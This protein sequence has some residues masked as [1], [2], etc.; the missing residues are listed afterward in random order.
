MDAKVADSAVGE[1][2]EEVTNCSG[3]FDEEGV[4][5]GGEG[6]LIFAD[7]DSGSFL[8]AGWMS[9]EECGVGEDGWPSI[10]LFDIVGDEFGDHWPAPITPAATDRWFPEETV[11]VADFCIRTSR[12]LR[13]IF[14]GRSIDATPNDLLE[15]GKSAE[16]GGDFVTA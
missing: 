7:S 5:G 4:V 11:G 12:G 1:V 9:S 6:G 15:F 13:N 3:M 2:D 8:S 14:R 16:E 10:G